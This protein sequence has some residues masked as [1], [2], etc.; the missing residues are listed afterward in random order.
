VPVRTAIS[1]ARC[2]GPLYS[3][4]EAVSLAEVMRI[5]FVGEFLDEGEESHGI[6]I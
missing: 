4:I 5:D 1:R 6:A 2:A 3:G